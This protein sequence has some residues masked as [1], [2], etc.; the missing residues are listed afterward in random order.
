[1][2]VLGTLLGVEGSLIVQRIT[3]K[4]EQ[5]KEDQKLLFQAF[6]LL[7]EH[8]HQAGDLELDDR[9]S[10]VG[11]ALRI[12]SPRYKDLAVRLDDYGRDDRI[13]MDRRKLFVLLDDIQIA[14]NKPVY[15]E[16]LRKWSEQI[17]KFKRQV[18]EGQKE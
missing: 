16:K 13:R 15:K 18:E 10:I 8:L 3:R 11:I 1:M 6:E 9:L 12:K 5:E 17:E 14:I 7:F 2:V 4:Y